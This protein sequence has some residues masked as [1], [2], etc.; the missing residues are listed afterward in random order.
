[1]EFLLSLQKR[2]NDVKIPSN[3][4]VW[5]EYSSVEEIKV[6]EKGELLFQKLRSINIGD[7][8]AM[9]ISYDFEPS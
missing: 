5:R 6:L 7:H 9:E 3:D 1:M 2:S 4:T 8:L